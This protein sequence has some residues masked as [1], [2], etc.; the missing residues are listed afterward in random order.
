MPTRNPAALAAALRLAVRAAIEATGARLLYLPPYSPNF[1]S[2]ENAFAKLE[3]ILRGTAARTV[4]ELWDAIRD[5][6]P[7]FTP[8]ECTN[9]FTTVGYEPE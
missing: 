5:A 7:Q 1:N 2:I 4:A 9:Y 6:L 3:A 8:A